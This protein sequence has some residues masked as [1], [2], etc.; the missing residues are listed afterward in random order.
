VIEPAA[1]R[2][3]PPNDWQ[4][5]EQQTGAQFIKS[6][7]VLRFPPRPAAGYWLKVSIHRYQIDKEGYI[8]TPSRPPATRNLSLFIQVGDT[9]P[10]G[11]IPRVQF[12][13]AG[14]TPPP[15]IVKLKQK[16]PRKWSAR[17]RVY[18]VMMN[19]PS[20]H[21]DVGGVAE[22]HAL[23]ALV[24][25]GKGFDIVQQPPHLLSAF[26]VVDERAEEV[27]QQRGIVGVFLAQAVEQLVE[28]LH[29]LF[30]FKPPDDAQPF[31]SCVH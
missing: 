10:F 4:Q 7:G 12:V 27:G 6:E 19:A 25:D 14:Q 26:R 30:R 8:R 24:L 3:L 29:L 13:Q 22:R 9:D 31:D 21:K 11:V 1:A 17:T 15:T 28:L 16:L 23:P 20:V 18:P 5:I 2:A